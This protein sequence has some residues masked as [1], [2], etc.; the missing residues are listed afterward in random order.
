VEASDDLDELSMD[1][2]IS[3]FCRKPEGDPD[4]E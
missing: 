2:I 1:D 3:G 4:A